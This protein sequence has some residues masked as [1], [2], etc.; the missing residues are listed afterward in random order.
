MVGVGGIRLQYVTQSGYP[1]TALR[2]PSFRLGAASTMDAV[3]ETS[4]AAAIHPAGLI[5]ERQDRGRGERQAYQ[6][7]WW[8]GWVSL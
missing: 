3:S 1:I 5:K 6:V 2:V 4:G 8:A 7:V